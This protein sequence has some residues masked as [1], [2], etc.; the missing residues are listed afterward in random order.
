MTTTATMSEKELNAKLE[1]FGGGAAGG[2]DG[3]GKGDFKMTRDEVDNLKSAF[4]KE[5]FRKMFSEYL[6]EMSDPTYRAEQEAYIRQCEM[7][8]QIPEGV[9][10][11]HPT[12][13]FVLKT[14]DAKTSQKYFINICSHDRIGKPTSQDVQAKGKKGKSWS[15]PHSIGP[16]HMEKDKSGNLC[17]TFDICF[18][19]EAVKK[20]PLSAQWQDFLAGIAIRGVEK[21]VKK[22]IQQFSVS[23]SMPSRGVSLQKEHHILRG[24]TCMGAQL[25]SMNLGD[26]RAKDER[27]KTSKKAVAT[28][29]NKPGS[30]FGGLS[31]GFLKKKKKKNV[32]TKI[33]TGG[34]PIEDNDIMKGDD[35]EVRKEA[36][37]SRAVPLGHDVP[38]HCIVHRQNFDLANYMSG[39]SCEGSSSSSR[40]SRRPVA[41]VVKIDLPKLSSAKKVD[42]DVSDTR[43][44]LHAEGFYHLDISLPYE[45]FGTRGVAKFDKSKRCLEVTIPVQPEVETT[46]EKDMDIIAPTDIDAADHTIEKTDE[47]TTFAASSVVDSCSSSREIDNMGTAASSTTAGDPPS[48][49][50]TSSPHGRWIATRK[51]GAE[52]ESQRF[53]AEIAR[54]AASAIKEASVPAA[55]STVEPD[56]ASASNDIDDA[57]A[58]KAKSTKRSALSEDMVTWTSNDSTEFERACVYE[59]RRAGYVFK[60]GDR[61]LGYYLDRPFGGATEDGPPP[62]RCQEEE[63]GAEMPPSKVGLGIESKRP[64]T[65]ETASDD[66]CT[67]QHAKDGA[68]KHPD[69]TKAIALGVER[70]EETTHLPFRNSLMWELD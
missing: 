39:P 32:V 59:G 44:T 9:D 31:R 53:A 56:P 14:R 25:A 13:S 67:R 57:T 8:N 28:R 38:T 62:I 24:V 19:S 69:R 41:I 16:K 34:R 22:D 40:A 3:T 17:P 42:L 60:T 33:S 18:H 5:E 21:R 55:T 2:G 48:P 63:E 1:E 45:V 49:S 43:L 20:C 68:S 27:E 7:R 4:K 6:E 64:P 36:S 10:I 26:A 12:P 50:S 35:I 52:L 51:S 37:T 23:A 58:A 65:V 70:E 11:I 54:R 46:T 15:V 61:G 29:E 66:S 47:E 30:S